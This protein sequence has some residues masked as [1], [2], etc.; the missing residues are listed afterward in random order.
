MYCVRTTLIWAYGVGTAMTEE[1]GRSRTG[2]KEEQR[3]DLRIKE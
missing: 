1:I 3:K 2:K